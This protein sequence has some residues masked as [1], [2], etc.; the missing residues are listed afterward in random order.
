MLLDCREY[1]VNP[2]TESL[3]KTGLVQKGEAG[4]DL[5]LHFVPVHVW[6]IGRFWQFKQSP[7]TAT[8]FEEFWRSVGP[9]RR[10]LRFSLAH[11]LKIF[12]SIPFWFLG[13]ASQQPTLTSWTK[14]STICS[15]G[16]GALELRLC[17]GLLVEDG[18]MAWGFKG[19]TPDQAM[20]DVR[21]PDLGSWKILDC[22]AMSKQ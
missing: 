16:A 3:D 17:R 1:L 2:N 10:C 6:E 14:A 15:H 22:K 20:Q 13:I 19:K 12:P 7:I 8:L 18:R 5:I 11:N 21:S 9:E 4:F